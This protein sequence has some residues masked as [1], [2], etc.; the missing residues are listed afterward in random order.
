[1]AGAQICLFNEFILKDNDKA[2]KAGS[3]P[4]GLTV[5]VE[6]KKPT[7]AL[8]PVAF[9]LQAVFS[10]LSGPTHGIGD[11]NRNPGFDAMGHAGQDRTNLLA[12]TKAV[13]C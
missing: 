8:L 13:R 6:N 5:G 12:F 11:A 2:V 10:L 4:E 9:S 3:P 7:W 1:M